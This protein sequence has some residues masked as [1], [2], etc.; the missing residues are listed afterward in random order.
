MP[1]SLPFKFAQLTSNLQPVTNS[2]NQLVQKMHFGIDLGTTNSLISVFENGQTR[3]ISKEPMVPSVVALLDGAL[4]VGKT[5]KQ[6]LTTHPNDTVAAFKRSMGT[7]KK[8]KLGRQKLSVVDL[9]AMVLSYLK[10]L[11]R[12]ETG[13][14][15]SD[16]VISVPAYFNQLQRDAVRAAALAADLNPL[17]LINEPTAAAIAYGLQDI[18]DQGHI[19]V[20]DLGGGTFDVSII[21]IF[22]GVLEVKATSGDA[23][24]GGEDFTRLLFHQ[25]ARKH[26]IPTEDAYVKARLWNA[27]EKLKVRLSTTH[28]AECDFGWGDRTERLSIS[29]EQFS[30]IS[31][32]LIRRLRLPVERA[33]Y[34]AKLNN[35][36]IDKVVLVGGATR[37]PLVR[38]QVSRM[39]GKLPEVGIDPDQVVAIGAAIQAALTAN[40]KALDDVVMTD[41]SAFSLG[42][43]ISRQFGNRVEHGFFEPVIERNTVIPASREQ[44]FS[45]MELGQTEVNFEL[46]QGESPRVL[47]NVKLGSLSV[48]VPRNRKEH[49]AIS[50]RLSYDTSGLLEIDTTVLSNQKTKSVVITNLTG[51]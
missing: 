47:D 1:K 43:A 4:V 19:M 20:F 5:A 30:E 15:V 37:M 10:E 44:I 42:F 51:G 29:R 28:E 45:T 48:K 26:T 40:D 2:L 35:S 14:N 21:E 16:V 33:L 8:Y 3:L 32:S 41:V 46:Y 34:D 18:D 25:L 7:D 27:A 11:A 9:S 23:F 50:V 22:E 31:S 13:V 49:E 39:V 6:R 12:D 17:R 38:T 24:L 36:Q